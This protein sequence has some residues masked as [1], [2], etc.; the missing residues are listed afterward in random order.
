MPDLCTCPHLAVGLRRLEQRSWSETCPGHGVGSA[1]FQALPQRP[2][3][4]RDEEFAVMTREQFL[5]LL[6]ELDRAEE[7]L[8][9]EEDD[10]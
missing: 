7:G 3:G 6:D 10:A 9:E 5:Q 1:Y 8:A 4:F 2:Y